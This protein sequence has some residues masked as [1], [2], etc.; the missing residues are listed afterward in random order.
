MR[1]K[2]DTQPIE[3][4]YNSG[5]TGQQGPGCCGRLSGDGNGYGG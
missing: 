2:L 3:K 1:R 5:T 4:I